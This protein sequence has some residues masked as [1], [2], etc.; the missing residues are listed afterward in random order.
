MLWCK[1]CQGR[2]FLDSV[3]SE[4]NHY[5]FFCIRCGK[6]PMVSK[7]SVFGRWLTRTTP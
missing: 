4:N 7:E 3:F 2:I 5:E 1:K 6:R